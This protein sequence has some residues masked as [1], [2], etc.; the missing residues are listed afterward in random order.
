[1]L[2][3]KNFILEKQQGGQ[4]AGSMEIDRLS[5]SE[6][7]RFFDKLLKRYQNMSVDQAIRNFG[8]NFKHAQ[9]LARRGK[10]KRRDMPVI[11]DY[12]VKQFQARLK[13]GNIDKHRPWA[14]ETN[15][16]NP[17][18]EGLSGPKAEHFVKNGLFDGSVED[19]VI[20]VRNVY[21]PV[22]QLIPIQRQIYFD[23]CAENSS[24]F[25]IAASKR[26]LQGSL[27]IQSEDHHILDGHHRWLS[28][29]LI[30]PNMSLPGIQIMLPLNKLLPLGKAYGDAMGNRRN[31]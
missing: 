2:K 26:F 25:G 28:A 4:D 5:L 15:P 24:K 12:Q 19:D 27:M 3:Y 7:K 13:N 20:R 14:K 11:E 21:T 10:T 6:A 23:K 29:M 8:N 1:M 9:S 30:D 17:F 31:A 16:R 22:K 18:P